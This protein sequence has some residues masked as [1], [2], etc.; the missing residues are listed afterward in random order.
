MNG[1]ASSTPTIPGRRVSQPSRPLI[2]LKR[3]WND[4]TAS[5]HPGDGLCSEAGGD[6]VVI[7]GPRHLDAARRQNEGDGRE[8]ADRD[9]RFRALLAPAHPDHDATASRNS[10]GAP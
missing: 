9:Q 8:D 4:R 10:S 7:V 6:P 5:P 3:F 1:A 2:W